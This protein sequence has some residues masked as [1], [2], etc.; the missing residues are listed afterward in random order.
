MNEKKTH[1]LKIDNDYYETLNFV[2]ARRL[3]ENINKENHY[4]EL[5]ITNKVII[6]SQNDWK[7]A[8]NKP[9]YMIDT[10]K[11][12]CDRLVLLDENDKIIEIISDR[13]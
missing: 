2:D 1:V 13:T 12:Y 7:N 4:L 8:N 11:D 6:K 5:Q 3:H 10:L 9:N